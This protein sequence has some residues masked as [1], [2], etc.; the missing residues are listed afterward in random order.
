MVYKEKPWEVTSIRTEADERVK[1][2]QRT[3]N[4][5]KNIAWLPAGK[6][7]SKHAGF[8]R[9]PKKV[10]TDIDERTSILERRCSNI[11]NEIESFKNDLKSMSVIYSTTYQKLLTSIKQKLD[12]NNI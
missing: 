1:S 11:E 12:I 10:F 6:V 4:T 5:S 7:G 9:H 3:Q 2:I 8:P